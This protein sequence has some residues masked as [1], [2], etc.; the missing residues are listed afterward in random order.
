MANSDDTLI[1]AATREDLPAITAIY[2]DEVENG[3]ASF[4]TVPPDLAEMTTRF[5]TVTGGGFPY[6][7]AERDGQVLGYAYAGAYHKRAAYRFTVED[8][9]YIDRAARG[10]GL[11]KVLMHALIERCA[12]A[13]FRQMI[14]II[15]RSA[16]S[17][18]SIGLHRA[19]GFVTVGELP[20]VGFKQGE[21]RGITIMQLALGA[22]ASA[23]PPPGR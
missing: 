5:E 23:P 6:I 12:Q 8:S 4:E 14:A 15:S 9:V 17:D 21:W 22:G 19:V 7:V 1:R 3:S 11:G 16:S 10:T 18:A 13:G 20:D 2:A